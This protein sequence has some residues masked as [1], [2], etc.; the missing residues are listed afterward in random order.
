MG[1]HITGSYNYHSPITDEE[2]GHSILQM[3]MMMMMM[4]KQTEKMYPLAGVHLEK[5]MAKEESHQQSIK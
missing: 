2:M 5:T 4:A 3:M 1:F